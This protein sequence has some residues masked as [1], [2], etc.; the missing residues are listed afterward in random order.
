MNRLFSIDLVRAELIKITRAPFVRS[1]LALVLGGVLLVV[2]MYE[3]IANHGK[4]MRWPQLQVPLVD[5]LCGGEAALETLDGRQLKFKLP[6]PFS[7]GRATKVLPGEGMPISKEPGKRGD[8]H[9]ELDVALPSLTEEQKARIK[10]L[11]PK[12]A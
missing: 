1:V 10:E 2:G 9:V 11:L 12:T 4:N 3:A 8:L 5:A 7:S 6:Q